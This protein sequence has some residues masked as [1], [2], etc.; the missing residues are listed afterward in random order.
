[1]S[2]LL[3]SARRNV[4]RYLRVNR[5]TINKG[6][7]VVMYVLIAKYASGIDGFASGSHNQEELRRGSKRNTAAVF[8][9]LYQLSLSNR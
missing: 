9:K 8:P 6:T 7:S 3:Y 5:H 2:H 1:V 4:W